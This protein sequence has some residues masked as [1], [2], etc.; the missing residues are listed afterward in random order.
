MACSFATQKSTNLSRNDYK[1]GVHGR[2]ASEFL[3][4]DVSRSNMYSFIGVVTG[5][6][7]L[8]CDGLC[9]ADDMSLDLDRF[10]RRLQ[11][12]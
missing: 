9:N 6:W 11:N 12:R 3:R 5:N 2:T 1:H 10:N 4:N 7:M 8:F